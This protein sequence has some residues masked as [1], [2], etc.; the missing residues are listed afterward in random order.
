VGSVF[1]I[2][3]SAPG[4]KKSTIAPVFCIFKVACSIFSWATETKKASNNVSCYIR[5]EAFLPNKG[6]SGA[7][8]Q[9]IK[10]ANL[11]IGEW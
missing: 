7:G 11:A 4:E 10:S 1:F 8:E 5:A 6:V 3:F 9:I 2:Y